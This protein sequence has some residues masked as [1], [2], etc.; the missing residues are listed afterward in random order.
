MTEATA[1]ADTPLWRKIASIGIAVALVAYVLS[2][3][4]PRTL[5]TTLA[6]THY[7]AF[8][9]FT[10]AFNAAL[11][12]ADS[13]ATTWIYRETVCPVRFR[14][15]FIVRGASYLPALLNHHVGQAWFTYF[16]SKKYRAPLWRVAGATLAVYATTFACLVVMGIGALPFNHGRVPWLAPVVIALVV[17][18]FA[19]LGVVYLRPS[20]LR[21][22]EAVAPLMELGVR[23]HLLAVAYRL[24]HVAVQFL[25]AWLPFFFFGV[26]IP[27]TDAL[28]LMPVLMLVVTLPITPQGI[29]TRD[30]LA[31]QLLVGY[32]PGTGPHAAAA[33]VA[34]TL[35]WAGATTLVQA[36][37]SPLFMRRAQRLL[38]AP[39]KA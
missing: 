30:V 21:H 33:I 38:V 14:E 3:L 25:G 35:S 17:G 16:L 10:L 24:P 2:R 11:L 9:A 31:L 7:I 39:S 37:L 13:F 29:G 20:F 32:A 19:Y 36:L 4:D 26:R 22:R 15:V 34:T 27:F 28:A 12:T 5:L 8:L 23:G 18:G 1:P 6:H